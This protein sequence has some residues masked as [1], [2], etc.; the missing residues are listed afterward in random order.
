LNEGHRHG[1]AFILF[2]GTRSVTK[3][4]VLG[5]LV[6]VTSFFLPVNSYVI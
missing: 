6:R 5:K 2:L 3:F 1:N 4:A